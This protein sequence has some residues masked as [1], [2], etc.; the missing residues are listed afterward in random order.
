MKK[1]ASLF[2]GLTLLTSLA[3][4]VG[5]E[6]AKA[7]DSFKKDAS[8]TLD[9][10]QDK[11]IYDP[12]Y[13]D[14]IVNPEDCPSVGELLRIDFVPQLNFS[15]QA[16]STED[17]TYQA[18][19]QLF[20]DTTGPRGN[21][22]QVSDYRGTAGGWILQ[23]RQE[24]QFK[25][26]TTEHQEL[27]GAVLSFDKSWANSTRDKQEAPIVSKETIRIDNIGQTYQLAE[28]KRGTGESTWSIEF[29]ASIENE[30][31]YEN[32]LSP[33]LDSKGD[34]ILSADYNNQPE[35]QNN[36]VTLFVPGK[37][38][39]DP[40]PYQTVLTWILSELP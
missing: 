18:N 3:L 34:P 14:K 25:N 24:T 38:E 20:Y 13:P 17:Q 10:I 28:A 16:I 37:T 1:C 22:I 15:Q 30:D 12:E 21:F 11:G 40:V 23:V 35:Y 27:K 36:A 9:V 4:S 8:I 2:T 32:T 29:G 39:K 33:R 5:F 6:S 26:D 31:G 7:E 19:A